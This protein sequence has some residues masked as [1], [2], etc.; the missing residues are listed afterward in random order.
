MEVINENSISVYLRANISTL[1]ERLLKQK[2]KR[3]LIA[4]IPD[5]DLPEFIAKHL[6]E[7]NPF[8]MKAQFT[9]P[10][11]HKNPDDIVSEIIHLLPH[12]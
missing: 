11:D 2:S 12:H 9:V 7:R 8:Y 4:N 1:T 10:T 3:P 6:F 5:E